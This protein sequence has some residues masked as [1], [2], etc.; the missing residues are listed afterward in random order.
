MSR[1]KE[2]FELKTN[3]EIEYKDDPIL[4]EHLI[5]FVMLALEIADKSPEEAEEMQKSFL[6][7]Y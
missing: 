2:K 5:Q 1:N 4:F 7:N 3:L 6:D